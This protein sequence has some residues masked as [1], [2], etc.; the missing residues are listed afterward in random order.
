MYCP[1][2][3]EKI[4][5]D[6]AFSGVKYGV[7]NNCHHEFTIKDHGTIEEKK[8]V[9]FASYNNKSRHSK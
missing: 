9:S 8:V 2:C 1:N 3:K 6:K 5:F 4:K 7:C